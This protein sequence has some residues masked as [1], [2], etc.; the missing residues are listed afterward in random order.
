MNSNS[1][2]SYF[3]LV[4]RGITGQYHHVSRAHLPRYL[5][6]FDHRWNTRDKTDSARTMDAL[7]GAEGKRLKYR[8]TR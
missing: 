4:K 8:E 1:V 5:A 6:E 2:E 7:R 3:S